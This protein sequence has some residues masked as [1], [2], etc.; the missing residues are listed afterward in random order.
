MEN[1][2]AFT[3][4]KKR[5]TRLYSIFSISLTFWRVLFHM[6]VT[7]C[8][9]ISMQTMTTVTKETRQ[10]LILDVDTGIDDAHAIMLALTSPAVDV[11]AITC[12][13]GNVRLEDATANTLRVL[14][15]V[16]NM[17]VS[18]EYLCASL[19][20]Y[21]SVC[22]RGVRFYRFSGFYRFAL[23]TVRKTSSF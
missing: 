2:H 23:F 1:I 9:L 11:V 21:L 16:G 17:G 18:A 14:R 6:C 3:L 7:I 10:K 8:P 12:A 15:A 4:S 13:N 22:T 20:L 5:N 19:S